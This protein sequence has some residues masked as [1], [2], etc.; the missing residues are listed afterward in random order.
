M[1][2]IKILQSEYYEHKNETIKF[3]ESDV[4]KL[5]DEISKYNYNNYADIKAGF[6]DKTNEMLR[7]KYFDGIHFIYLYSKKGYNTGVDIIKIE[8]EW[9]IAKMANICNKCDQIEGLLKYLK[10]YGFQFT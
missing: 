5:L 3:S 7:F 1:D 10:D 6:Y 2:Y 9:F 4:K 8:D